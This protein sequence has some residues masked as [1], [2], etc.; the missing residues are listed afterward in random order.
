M[1][2]TSI[3]LIEY[4][5]Q[6]EILQETRKF[7][8][9]SIEGFLTKSERGVLYIVSLRNSTAKDLMLKIKINKLLFNQKIMNILGFL[10]I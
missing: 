4:K 5:T 1:T 6:M 2:K 10:K 8:S 9:K 7:S 3:N